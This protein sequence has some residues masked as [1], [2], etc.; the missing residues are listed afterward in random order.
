MEAYVPLSYGGEVTLF[1]AQQLGVRHAL[2]GPIDPYRGWGKLAKGGVTIRTV[3]STHI[4]LLTN[5]AVSDLAEQLNAALRSA[6]AG[7]Q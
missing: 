6:M 3:N 5:P 7:G 2:F 4:G 1:R